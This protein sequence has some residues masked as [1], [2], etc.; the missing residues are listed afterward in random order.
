MIDFSK[1][2]LTALQAK[3]E[4]QKLAFS[5]IVF[6]AARTLR[7]LGILTV[8]DNA[9]SQG[10]SA[11]EIS[12]Q[13]NV[14]EYGVKV[15]LEMALSA[16][17]VTWEKPNY[18]IANLGYFLLHDKMTR[19][20]LDFTADVCYAAMMHLTE[21]IQKGVPAGLKELG[22]WANIYEGLSILPG[23]AKKA[24][25]NSTI[26]TQ[27]ELSLFFCKPYLKINLSVS[28]ILAA[29]PGD[30]LYNALIMIVM[31]K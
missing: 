2:P 12:R 27:I 6:H 23:K 21:S 22:N 30:G 31:S 28:L 5:P 3:N 25:L 1:D 29:T 24:G 19:I 13:T 15:L 20:N 26:S 18:V 11:T 8:L 7:D 14:S 16:H 17:I 4:A 10:L 9:Q